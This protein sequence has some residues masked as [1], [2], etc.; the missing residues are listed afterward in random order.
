MNAQR[1]AQ[2]PCL[3]LVRPLLWLAAAAFAAGF[4]GYLAVAGRALGL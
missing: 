4:G 1:P 2:R 3:E